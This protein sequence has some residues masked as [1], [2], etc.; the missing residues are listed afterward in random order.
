[1]FWKV[2]FHRIR[3]GFP[4][5]RQAATSQPHDFQSV[6]KYFPILFLLLFTLLYV[7][8]AVKCCLNMI[9]PAARQKTLKG[10]KREKIWVKAKDSAEL[11]VKGRKVHA[12]KCSTSCLN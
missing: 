12:L 6:H 1:V 5:S 9:L 3:P 7:T 8:G 2:D 11:K 4:A 10:L